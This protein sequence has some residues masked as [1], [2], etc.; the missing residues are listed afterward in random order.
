M[1]D[2]GILEIVENGAHYVR[3]RGPERC[4]F[5]GYAFL[6]CDA[7]VNS[8]QTFED[9][10]CLHLQDRRGRTETTD[11]YEIFIPT[12][13]NIWCHIL[14]VILVVTTFLRNQDM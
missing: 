14:V 10:D 6:G 9:T 2:T 3:C 1:E 13:R 5:R 12:Y 7:V 11:L 8:C 4:V